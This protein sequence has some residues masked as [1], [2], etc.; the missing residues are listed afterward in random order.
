MFQFGAEIPK[1]HLFSQFELMDEASSWVG[2]IAATRGL[3][4][5][6]LWRFHFLYTGPLDKARGSGGKS[7]NIKNFSINI[8]AHQNIILTKPA[9]LKILVHFPQNLVLEVYTKKLPE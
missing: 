8:S 3:F 4:A 5:R 1:Q 2:M 9:K 6:L 7:I